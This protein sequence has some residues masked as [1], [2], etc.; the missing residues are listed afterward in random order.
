MTLQKINLM[1]AIMIETVRSNGISNEELIGKAL[2]KEVDDLESLSTDFDFERLVELAENEEIFKSIIHDGYQVSFV[3]RNG[4]KNLLKLKFQITE[5]DYEQIENGYLNLEIH[6]DTLDSIR[7]L[8]SANWK[9]RE[10]ER[11]DSKVKVNIT[12]G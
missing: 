4:L 12:V 11:N 8:I 5:G 2:N 9:I 7:E 1:D 3:T 10:I 6:E